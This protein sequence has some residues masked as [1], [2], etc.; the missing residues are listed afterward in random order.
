MVILFPGREHSIGILEYVERQN[1]WH[2]MAW[3]VYCQQNK[4]ISVHTT[5]SLFYSSREAHY[6]S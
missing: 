2:C 3:F 4:E 5:N 1:A 6:I